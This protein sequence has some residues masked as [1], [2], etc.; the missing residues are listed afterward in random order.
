MRLRRLMKICK[1]CFKEFY[2]D[3]IAHLFNKGLC[4]CKNC[5]K[6]IQGKFIK[7][8][9]DGVKALSIYDY[10]DRIQSLLY[11]FKGCFDV[12]LRDIFLIRYYRELSLKYHG[13]I[14]VPIP[15]Y[16]EDDEIREFNHVVEMFKLLKL[17]VLY[18][19]R[20]TAPMKQ[21][22]SKASQRKEIISG[23]C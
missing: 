9:I 7:F 20:K 11:Q 14:V 5:M 19:L 12:E 1:L 16:F 2:D 3:S 22:T 10:D 15:S 18:L 21:A 4:F 23:M 6:D 8:D 13:Y 17:R